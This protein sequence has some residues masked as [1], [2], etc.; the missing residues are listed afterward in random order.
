[1][2]DRLGVRGAERV[3]RLQQDGRGG[4]GAHPAELRQAL[5]QVLALQE[6]HHEVGPTVG[7]RAEVRDVDDVRVADP[8]DGHR[9]RAEAAHQRRV[10]RVE[11]MH[12]LDRHQPRD[13]RVLGAVDPPHPAFAEQADHAVVADVLP[14]ERVDLGGH[15]IAQGTV[16]TVAGRVARDSGGDFTGRDAG[17]DGGSGKVGHRAAPITSS[18]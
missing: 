5:S 13:L 15:R 7:E 1:V 9:L 3:E 14:D 18:R 11:C 8:V 10:H 17:D 4:L 2:D 16:A 6:L 12:D